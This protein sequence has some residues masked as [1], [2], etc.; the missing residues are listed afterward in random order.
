MRYTKIIFWA[1]VLF[2]V[3][4]LMAA[5]VASERDSYATKQVKHYLA[6]QRLGEIARIK[7]SHSALHTSKLFVAMVSVAV[8][9]ALRSAIWWVSLASHHTIIR[10]T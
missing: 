1:L 8:A 3:G 9:A 5:F 7:H 4:I 6:I 2:G 10:V